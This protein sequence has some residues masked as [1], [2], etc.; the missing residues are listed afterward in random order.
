TIHRQPKSSLTCGTQERRVEPE[1]VVGLLVDSNGFP[2]EIHSFEGNTAETHTI[3]PV[4]EAFQQRHQV[5]DMVAVAD[6]GM[7]SDKNLQAIDEAGLRFIV[8]SK[9]TKAP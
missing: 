7:L 3:L 4:L 1:G 8:G 6:A 2:L 5:A 9:Q